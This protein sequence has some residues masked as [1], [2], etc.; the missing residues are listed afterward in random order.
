MSVGVAELVA[1]RPDNFFRTGDKVF[2]NLDS[3]LHNHEAKLRELRE[4]KWKFA[5]FD[6]G[7]F[8]VVG[9][10]E[11]TAALTGMPLF[12]AAA[13]TTSILGVTPTAKDLKERYGKLREE[14]KALTSSGVG[15]LFKLR[16]A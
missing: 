10:I 12:G 11:M 13:A 4:K 5:G 3:A 7:S 1:A 9:G 6:V 8:L 15:I 2:E 16:G 14:S